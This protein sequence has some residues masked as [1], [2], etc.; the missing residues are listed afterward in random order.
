MDKLSRRDLKLDENDVVLLTVNRFN[1]D[2]CLNDL[3]DAF[4]FI[5]QTI[6]E[7]KLILIGRVE[8][9]QEKRVYEEVMERIKKYKIDDH[10]ICCKNVPEHLLYDYYNLS[11]IYISPTIRE[12]FLLSN[13]QEA[14]ACGLP[15][16]STGQEPLVKSGINGYI[17]PKKNPR[18]I[19]EAV[20]KIHNENKY[21]VFGA[22]S[23]EIVK[24]YDYKSLVKKAIQQYEKL[25]KSKSK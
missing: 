6:K 8:D 9:E 5:R 10:I 15:V 21:K 23:R 25:L 17:V 24:N 1:P 16:V 14:M 11:N 2:R 20:L 19:A 4:A 18:A 7:A 13:I 3:V 22:M 12:D